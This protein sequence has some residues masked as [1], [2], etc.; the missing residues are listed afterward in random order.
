[1][2][3]VLSRLT[4]LIG[5]FAIL[6]T[7]VSGLCAENGVVFGP[8]DFAVGSWGV[9]ASV[10]RFE[11]DA[12]AEGSL[13]VS[14]RI[15]DKAFKGG[16]VLVNN[17][18]FSL[19]EFLE[20][21]QSVFVADVNLRKTNVIGLTLIGEPGAALSI[22]VR[23]TDIVNLPQATFSATPESIRLGEAS[24][25]QWTSTDAATVSIA[26]GIGDV[27]PSGSQIASP[28]ATTTYTLTAA[29]P[30]GTATRTATVTVIAPPP[31]VS[32]SI[33]PAS[34]STGDIVVLTWS[35]TNVQS[36]AIEPGIGSVLLPSGT[37]STAPVATTTYT[38]TALGP[39]GSASASATVTV[40]TAPSV[41]ISAGSA[42]IPLGGS[43]TLTWNVE[44]AAA[45]YID[46]GIGPV[47]LHDTA[48]ISP[49]ATTTYTLTASGKGGT[50][51]AKATV[52]VT[53]APVLQPP[54]SFG[55][56]YQDQVPSDAT[57]EVYDVK[58]F[59]LVTGLVRDALGGA[60]EGVAVSIFDHPGYGSTA[61]D[62][63]GRFTLPVEGGGILSVSYRKPGFI[64]A[65]RQVPVPWNDI[66]VV[67][68]VSLV[69]E[70]A[71]ATVVKFDGS[72]AT[73]VT[74]R[75]RE[76]SDSSGTRA[77]TMV[78]TGDNMAYL[79]DKA[80]NKILDLKSITTRAT[81]FT[82]PESMPAKLPPTSAFTWCA[83]LGVDGAERVKFD[84][85]VVVWVENFLNFPVGEIVPVGHYDRDKA[86][87]VPMKN[88]VVAELLDTDGDGI[89]DAL[90][91]DGDGKPD[92]L[93]K[94]GQFTDEVRG[95]TDSHKYAA[96]GTFWRAEV[97]H[98]SPIDFNWPFGLP[99]GAIPPNPKNQAFADDQREEG[100]D[101]VRC[102]GSFVEEKGR[103]FHDDL[104]I[105]GTD[106]NLHYS[107]S[108]TAGYKPG[109][110]NIPVSGDTVPLN[111][112]KIIVRAEVAGRKYEVGLSTAPNQ[113]A[114][115]EWDG[116]DHLG[117]LVSGTVTA[118]V[119]IGF[120]YY[121]VYYRAAS[122]GD[123]FGQPGL[124]SLI[125]PTRQETVSWKSV[126]VRI[127]RGIG[128]IAEGW[129]LSAHHYVSP[130][131]SSRIF[132]GDGTIG[133]NT[134]AIIETVAGDGTWARVFGGMGGS[135]VKAQIGEPYDLATDE[136]G[137]LYI[138]SAVL[139]PYSHWE[140]RI[141]KVDRKGI[142]TELSRSVPSS[143]TG[144]AQDAQGNYYHTWG[145]YNCIYKVDTQNA[146]TIFGTCNPNYGG[147]FSGDGG[148][149][150]VARF[151]NPSGIDVDQ[152]GNVY[153]ADMYNHRIR[154]IDIN[155]TVTT[156]AG[157]GAAA[158]SGDGGRATEAGLPDPISVAADGYGNVFIAEGYTGRVRKVDPS[159]TIITVAGN[160]TMEFKGNGF[161]ATETGFYDIRSI[162]VDKDGN[163]YIV[164]GIGNRVY[165]VDTSG[166]VSTVAGSGPIGYGQGGFEGDG[167]AATA[168][169]LDYPAAVAVDPSGYIYIA[170]QFNE[171]V[172]RVGPQSA[173][174]AALM[175][176]SDIAFSEESGIG[177]ILS[178]AG[179]HKMTIDLAT[180]V[181]LREFIYDTENR[182]I[183]IV[184]SFEN[185]TIIELGPGGVA[186]AIVSPDGIRT[187]LSINTANQLTGI[188]YPGGDAYAFNY[189]IDG[190][191]LRKT[192][193]AGNS[194]GHFYDNHGRITDYMDN[195]GGHWQLTNRLLEN[196]DVRHETL[197]AEGGLT[198]HVDRYASSG[199]YQSTITDAAGAQTIVNES[200]DRFT[201]ASALA[202][203]I[204]REKAYDLDPQYK[205]KYLRK[206]TEQS[207][208]GLK[209]VTESETLY[210]D[211]D[212]DAIPEVIT[213]KVRVNGRS[214]I[215]SQ[216]IAAAKRILTSA[217][218][219]TVILEYDPNTL[220]TERVIVPGLLDANYTHDSRGRLVQTAV[221]D[222]V[223]AFAYTAQGFLGTVTDAQGRTSYSHDALGRVKQVNR[224]DQSKIQFDYDAN[225]NLTVLV[226]PSGVAHKFGYNK[227]NRPSAYTTPLSGSYQYRYDRDRRPTETELPSGRIIR[228][229]YDQGRLLRTETPEAS[230]YFNYL[231]GSKLASITR[232]GESI[233]YT[234]DGSLLT[235]ETSSGSLNQEVSYSY[236][237]DFARVQATYAGQATGYGYDNDGLLTQAG[238]FA[239]TRHAGNGLPVSVSGAGLQLNRGFNDHGEVA[240][241][242]VVVNGKAVGS[243]SLL[244]DNAGR[245]VRKTEAA[246][247]PASSYDYVYNSNGRLVRVLKDGV[248]VEEYGYDEN[249][250]R[251]F[252]INTQRGIVNR[253][254]D[255]SDEDH[256][257]KA[258]EWTYQYDL[259]GFLIT[260]NNSTNKT[261]YYYS[262]RGELLTVLLPDGKRIDYVCD[263]LGRR[264]A[265]KV[266]GVVVEKYLWQGLTRILAVYDGGNI[267]RQRFEYADERM[268]VAMKT[269]GATYYL[270]YDQVGSLRLV[271]DGSG[272]VVK[273]ITYDSF[274]NILE[275]TNPPF[276]I[277]FGFAGGLHDS[278]T[279]LVRFGYRDYDPEV[280]RWTAKDPI[281]FAGGDTD[282]YGYVLNDPVNLVDPYGLKDW[283]KIIG[284]GA[285]MV[286]SLVE[287]G[288]GGA[289]MGVG[290]LEIAGGGAAGPAGLAVAVPV[291]IH[292]IGLGGVIWGNAALTGNI[293][294][295]FFIEGWND[296]KEN[297]CNGK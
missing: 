138:A 95:L 57:V 193:P 196:G 177:Y 220:I 244:R 227:V 297:P 206:L 91:A 86:A 168:A 29:G 252:E 101:A 109:V 222:R 175:G 209:R 184:D 141:L 188:T 296:G 90:D 117:R 192:Q 295:K 30:G 157:T 80:G 155:G 149:A 116:L 214:S 24:T 51:G 187:V 143:Q 263:P 154:K 230:I 97:T 232:S 48:T 55:K 250:T 164:S 207:P 39:G 81:E 59:A 215:L 229:V 68:T 127:I 258:G 99:P 8:R 279:G 285:I 140:H 201:V 18:F 185:R 204:N 219:R 162:T 77:A 159:G 266:N 186:T 203:G 25:L 197:T 236:D 113:V 174:L 110:I 261:L 84:K 23:A 223:T 233:S 67:D 32:L 137:N 89:V 282:L 74:H 237:N 103:I 213:K 40:N 241:Q 85:P 3:S 183:A 221:G 1:M 267:L 259:D 105:P 191:E 179:L 22:E 256:L 242:T 46:Q 58:R 33:S 269:G 75:S 34:I 211:A 76:V 167:G 239:I 100:K 248:L 288:V 28:Q 169:K 271:A 78:F 272:N 144:F 290:I 194:F 129:S 190:L 83:E 12:N 276:T 171:R 87:W 136:E 88:G 128:T 160:G 161:L 47:A 139:I 212:M 216:D 278:D 181:I 243:W 36:A 294:A 218:G 292:T 286:F 115:I 270:S 165:K 54:G 70:D 262:S 123:A 153:I 21:S 126:D 71:A 156:F 17:S 202:C 135:A 79:T 111:L 210:T 199:A 49:T 107:S 151:S 224:P 125:V 16:F 133:T 73:V 166:I 200:A 145:Y 275:D 283:G 94:N 253:S 26:P 62:R 124:S 198:T 44:G 121:G 52:F 53:G 106:L 254:Y 249:G 231:C 240:S 108:R 264:I 15:T 4:R 63:D 217:E 234:Y 96:G 180:G 245:I 6:C 238:P 98:F 205:Y 147:G 66:A 172:R 7:P 235:S 277:P 35:S 163:L 2:P 9:H 178:A 56:T 247:G 132:K 284:G 122:I 112:V 120:V 61:T 195:E 158:S 69:F 60:L 255:Y 130:M 64:S 173:R 37:L 92:D 281:G 176:P 72:P 260:K 134:T 31:T 50:A 10:H 228:N 38:I 119:Q 114:Q 146:L 42:S 150:T 82:T 251:I 45:A 189:S 41:T 265:K 280:G 65:Q 13:V 118:H 11:C 148:P 287:A 27:A 274:G 170:D 104:P 152:S 268:P 226:N 182:L 14:R 20:G 291:G 289:I 293:G 131:D 19:H 273:R 142:V 208:S 246:G 225:G 93:N 102:L 257:L 43:T 5:F